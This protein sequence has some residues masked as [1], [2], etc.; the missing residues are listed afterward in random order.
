MSL[1]PSSIAL[2]LC[3]V[4]SS[5]APSSSAAIITI[6]HRADHAFL[7]VLG[8]GGWVYVGGAGWG[9]WKRGSVGEVVLR[10]TKDHESLC[11]QLLDNDDKV[12]VVLV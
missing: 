4:S 7:A 6:F 2:L 10:L 1:S 9:G 11:I 5:F 3:Y 8:G 12:I